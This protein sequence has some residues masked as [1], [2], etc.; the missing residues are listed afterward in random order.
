MN[1]ST[2][3][4]FDLVLLIINIGYCLT[5]TSKDGIPHLSPTI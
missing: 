4:L 2:S 1:K 5:D 3:W